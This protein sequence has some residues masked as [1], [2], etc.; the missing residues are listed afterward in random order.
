MQFVYW[1]WSVGNWPCKCGFWTEMLCLE[2]VLC[3]I[4]FVLIIWMIC[5]KSLLVFLPKTV[6]I[7]SSAD[8]LQPHTSVHPVY[9]HDYTVW[10]VCS[11]KIH[12][13][14]LYFFNTTYAKSQRWSELGSKTLNVTVP[15]F[16]LYA[17]IFEEI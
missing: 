7:S 10:R 13:D 2:L 6:S 14:K 9:K 1:A 17:F 11:P 16:D 12:H 15:S 8:L 4:W 5:I 3:L